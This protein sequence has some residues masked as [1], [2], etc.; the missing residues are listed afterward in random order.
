MAELAQTLVTI[1]ASQICVKMLFSVII[2]Y[3]EAY[4]AKRNLNTEY[5]TEK[6]STVEEQYALESYDIMM[7]VLLDYSELSIRF[8]FLTLFVCSC[9]VIPFL[10]YVGN[11]IEIRLD[12]TD[13]LYKH[14]R[15]IPTGCQDIG[16]WM[17]IFELTANLSV[18]T[19]SAIICFT[20]NII[21]EPASTKVWLFIIFQYMIFTAMYLFSAIIDD[22]PE[23]VNIQL[24]REEYIQEKVR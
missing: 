18:I 6:V 14:R 15:P 17:T 2:P 8:G 16:T 21:E 9:P 20:M 11:V 4:R 10:V 12:A 23:D 22:V 13:L 5:Q 3:V 7:D 24:E 19:N 1:V